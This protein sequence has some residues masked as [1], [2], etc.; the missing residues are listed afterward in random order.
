MI[1][2]NEVADAYIACGNTIGFF[3][4]EM[5][6]MKHLPDDKP[7]GKCRD[8]PVKDRAGLLKELRNACKNKEAE[9]IE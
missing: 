6:L 3:W 7:D 9:R 4:A 2:L 1:K 8:V 5:I